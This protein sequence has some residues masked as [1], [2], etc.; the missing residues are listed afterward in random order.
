[1]NPLHDFV[2]QKIRISKT[3]GIIPIVHGSLEFTLLIRK[4]FYDSPPDLVLIELPYFIYEATVKILPYLNSYPII[5]IEGEIPNYIIFEPLEPIVETLRNCY[6]M[7]IPFYLIDNPPTYSK[8]GLFYKNFDDFPDTFVLNYL[9]L[10]ELYDIYIKNVKTKTNPID[11][12]R[13]LFLSIQIK[14]IEIENKDKQILVI[15]GFKHVKNIINF[16]NK[17]LKDLE[18]TYTNLLNR[19]HLRENSK[20]NISIHS[21]SETSP[22]LLSQPGY[23]NNL[24]IEYRKEPKKWIF[25]NR[26]LLQKEVYRITKNEYEQVSGEFVAPQ[27][28]KLFFQFSRNLSILYKKLL[29]NPL[30]LIYS[31]K[32]FVNDNFAK[33]FY[34]KLMKFNKEKSIFEELQITLEDIGIDS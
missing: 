13:E 3:L 9:S 16:Y 33:I 6:E 5:K 10:Q 7:N 20:F 23:Y 22:E 14:K 12:F 17:S 15:C 29:P 4:H 34:E 24:W 11:L 27:K 32:N 1:M 2:D 31:A 26:I 21:L 19:L 30:I 28:E 18:I 25:F 8:F